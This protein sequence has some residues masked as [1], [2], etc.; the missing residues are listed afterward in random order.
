MKRLF[1]L[2][3]LVVP[4]ALAATSGPRPEWLAPLQSDAQRLV[5][6]WQAASAEVD[7]ALPGLA[8]QQGDAD[9]ADTAGDE[10]SE[11]AEGDTLASCRGGLM[12]DSAN[13]TLIYLDHVQ[14][15]D[16]RLRLLAEHRLFVKLRSMNPRP[17]A[18]QRVDDSPSKEVQQVQQDI[19][20]RARQVPQQLSGGRI[21][22]ET[23]DAVADTASNILLLRSPARGIPVLVAQGRNS[24]RI[25]PQEGRE[26]LLVADAAGNVFM[27]GAHISLRWVDDEGREGKM[28]CA[29]G[30]ITYH[31]A[32]HTLYLPGL[33]SM[34][35]PRG[36]FHS[37][38]ALTVVLQPDPAA[39]KPGDSYLSQFAKMRFKGVES[40]AVHQGSAKFDGY[41]AS[42]DILQYNARTGACLASGP[43]A[44]LTY[45][46]NT[47]TAER[48]ALDENGNIDIHG[49]DVRVAYE[50]F[51]RRNPET[52]LHGTMRCGSLHFD[53]AS[54]KVT[55]QEP[56]AIHD[57]ELDFA[58][59]GP[60]ELN[61]R[62]AE[63]PRPRPDALPSFA[64]AEFDGVETL[65]AHRGVRLAAKSEQGDVAVMGDEVQADLV[66]QEATVTASGDSP[67]VVQGS[68][69]RAAAQ[70]AAGADAHSFLQVTEQGEISLSGSHISIEHTPDGQAPSAIVA[71]SPQSP[72]ELHVNAAG[73]IS[74]KGADIG[75]E[76]HDSAGNSVKAVCKDSLT[77]EKETGRLVTGSAT[78]MQ[79]AQGSFASN[80]PVTAT[81][82]H[83]TPRPVRQDDRFA[84]LNYSFDGL[85]E[86][87]TPAGGSI[88]TPQGSMQCSG[89][90]NVAFFADGE[91]PKPARGASPQQ[92]GLGNLKSA[93]AEGS[94]V[95]AA[96]DSSGR[97]LRASGDT[98]TLDAVTGVKT[99]TGNTVTLS[100]RYN[101]HTASGN[102]S[103]T[104]DADNNA[105][106]HGATQRT[107]ATQIHDQMEQQKKGN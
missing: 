79:A 24:I 46:A 56:V 53:A 14:L 52:K 37:E 2:S 92:A 10:P 1:L 28:E 27:D 8:A 54:G 65:T 32:S 82:R 18:A 102:A 47:I 49:N 38:A 35:H 11:L 64:L 75:I 6:Q 86:A 3:A 85:Q 99:L 15:L 31:A 97:V 36:T 20:D 44:S 29:G 101:T 100:D 98:V 42:G 81:L 78:R 67:L 77:L 5:E 89:P 45:N 61:L 19:T 55:T 25:Q 88:R 39:G 96:K 105:R 40:V 91:S 70:T 7:A 69:F 4:A 57:D 50:R 68:G 84:H 104:L 33:S 87:S 23:T 107:T 60:T 9:D 34:E 94:V 90:M 22:I 80:G 59:Q 73:D 41:A 43:Q 83:G 66:R 76:T 58:A 71:L 26:A 16:E 63:T 17:D 95:L 74:L 48:I 13:S 12:F 62:R 93:R 72:A 51:S 30:S 21:T 103:I 106:I